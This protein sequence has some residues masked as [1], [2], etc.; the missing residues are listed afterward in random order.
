MVRKGGEA[1]EFVYGLSISS[2][3]PSG[4]LED[5]ED[6]PLRFVS[7]QLQLPDSSKNFDIGWSMSFCVFHGGL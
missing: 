2:L 3:E 1:A 5:E 4:R 6:M 7:V